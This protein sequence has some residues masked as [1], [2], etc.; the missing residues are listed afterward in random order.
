MNYLVFER[1][2]TGDGKGDV[3]HQTKDISNHKSI[4]LSTRS[5][6]RYKANKDVK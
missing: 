1:N 2:E 3:K 5:R 4:K 6:E